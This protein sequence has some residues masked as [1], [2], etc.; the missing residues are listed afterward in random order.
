MALV[1][2]PHHVIP[3]LSPDVWR[4]AARGLGVPEWYQPDIVADLLDEWGG[5]HGWPWNTIRVV[6]L[7]PGYVSWNASAPPA[8]R[9]R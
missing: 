2:D 4:I 3:T 1:A 8:S 7:V 5:R 6:E 9:G